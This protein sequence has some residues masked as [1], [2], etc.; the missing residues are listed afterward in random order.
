M[1]FR[2]GDTR[3]RTMFVLL[4]AVYLLGVAIN[5][6]DKFERVGEPDVGW[7]IDDGNI[8]P[9]RPEVS[10]AGLRGG[11]RALEINGV[12]SEAQKLGRRGLDR[13]PAVLVEPGAT[14]VL[15]FQ[16]P[17]GEIAEMEIVVRNWEWHDAIFS[18]GATFALGLLFFVVGT[19]TF[20]LRPYTPGSW[21]LLALCSM[22]GG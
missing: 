2:D 11:G 16:R 7:V 12:P 14:N 15:R 20:V 6:W 8:S 1:R 18:E 5:V 4:V 13:H 9:T 19:T 3:Q 22:V 10:D 21:A 17:T